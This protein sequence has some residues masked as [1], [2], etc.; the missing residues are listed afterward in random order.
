M[1][2]HNRDEEYL[3]DDDFI[4]VDRFIATSLYDTFEFLYQSDRSN[5]SE[6][7]RH[8]LVICRQVGA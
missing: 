7:K 3:Q 1:R 2:M 5:L 6:K 4:A 8:Y